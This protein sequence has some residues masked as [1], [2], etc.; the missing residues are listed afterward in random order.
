MKKKFWAIWSN[1][2]KRFIEDSDVCNSNSG[3]PVLGN[4]FPCNGADKGA[5]QDVISDN[6]Q[7]DNWEIVEVTVELSQNKA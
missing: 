5:L 3:I 6:D 7:E 2:D 4:T 1:S